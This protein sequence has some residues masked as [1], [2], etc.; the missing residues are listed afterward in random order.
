[1]SML[2][3]GGYYAVKKQ[4]LNVNLKPTTLLH[5]GLILTNKNMLI[6]KLNLKKENNIDL[7]LLQSYFTSFLDIEFHEYTN[8]FL[9][10]LD[11]LSELKIVQFLI[12]KNIR[13]FELKNMSFEEILAHQFRILNFEDKDYNE[14]E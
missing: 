4:I 7:N 8:Y 11:K 12:Q 9:L 13:G 5:E 6:T 3:R 2:I 10:I 1:M 14:D